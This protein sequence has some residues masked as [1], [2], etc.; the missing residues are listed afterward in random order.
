MWFELQMCSRRTAQKAA[1]AFFKRRHIKKASS[2]AGDALKH[3]RHVGGTIE[4]DPELKW[5]CFCSL[6][7][8]YFLFL[9]CV[10]HVKAQLL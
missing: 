1:G 7:V 4:G 10:L 6:P 8:V 3:G 9:R 2:D 5:T